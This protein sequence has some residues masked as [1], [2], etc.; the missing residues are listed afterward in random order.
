MRGTTVRFQQQ[1]A[2]VRI[3]HR[4]LR[5]LEDESVVSFE[6]PH[7]SNQNH[8]THLLVQLPRPHPVSP[9]MFRNS[10]DGDNTTIAPTGRLHQV[11]YALEAVK[12]GSAVV[13]MRSK[14]H[15]VL[16]ALK[17]AP[18]ELAAHQHKLLS[19]DSHIGIGFA[20]LTNDARVLSN[21]MRQ[22]ALSSRIV[23]SRPLPLSRIA[24]SLADRAQLNTMEYGRRPYGVGFLIIGHDAK[25]PHL[26]EF[27]PVGTCFEYHAMSLGA[28]SQSAKTYL[29][30][31]LDEYKDEEDVDKLVLHALSALRETLQQGKEVSTTSMRERGSEICSLTGTFTLLLL[32]QLEASSLSVALV[33]PGSHLSPAERL[34]TGHSAEKFRIIEGD[35]LKTNYLDKMEVRKGATNVNAPS[36]AEAGAAGDPSSGTQAAATDDV[37]MQD[38]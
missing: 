6:P 12:Q 13:G 37:Q 29:E 3:E 20:G 14:T 16:V 26:Y 7:H 2:R 10:Y 28:R 15:A 35:E 22:L 4:P 34:A 17:R 27:S 38:Q 11:E 31:K 9:D 25:G 33:G 1:L 32:Q 5:F 21:Y 30:R 24:G 18:S 8:S 19:I 36:A 23:Y